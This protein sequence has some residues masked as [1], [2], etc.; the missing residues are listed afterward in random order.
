M[1]SWIPAF[2]GMTIWDWDDDLGDATRSLINRFTAKTAGR[3][4]PKGMAPKEVLPR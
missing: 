2:A 3:K 4:K 1:K